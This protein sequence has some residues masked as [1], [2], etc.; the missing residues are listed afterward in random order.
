MISSKDFDKA[1]EL[2]NKSSNILLTTHIRP[3]GDA[4]GSIIALCKNLAVMGKSV[5]PLM[6]SEI[7]Q[8]YEFLFEKKPAVLES[9]Y[10]FE[11]LKDGSANKYD[12]V[13]I[14]DTN[15]YGQLPKFEEY[16]KQ[17][18]KAVLVI[19]HHVTSDALGDVELV[20]PTAAAAGLVVFDLFKY[21]QWPVTPEIAMAL[22]V[23]IATDTGWFQFNNTDSRALRVCADLIDSGV[24][25]TQVHR[26]LYHNLSPQR[27]NLTTAMLN[28]LK[29]HFNGRY[30]EQY[31]LQTHFEQTGATYQDTENLIDQCRKI[32]SVEAAALFVEQKDGRIKCSLR[33]TSSIDVRR[34]AQKF[35]G[36][37]HVMAAGLHLPGP[38]DNARKIIYELMKEQFSAIDSK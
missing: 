30:A 37:G 13:I 33:S 15:C 6:L 22:F 29:L 12:L 24:N 21:A 23:A 19:D 20:D 36:G 9:D 31:I 17:N 26:D 10:T 11:Q 2:I 3:D 38:V 27:F 4:C 28:T 8:W 25:P 18:E 5:Q 32:S 7:P 1:I 35:G 16:L 14:V 34:I